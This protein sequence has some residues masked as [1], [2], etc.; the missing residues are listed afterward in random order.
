MTAWIDLI[1]AYALEIILIAVV[2][3]LLIVSLLWRLLEASYRQLWQWGRALWAQ[4]IDLAPVRRLL[5]KYPRLWALL[6]AR[7]SPDSYLGLHLTLGVLFMLAAV[8]LFGSL[9]EQVVEEESL[10]RF[11]QDLAAALH[12]QASPLE[13][14]IFRVVTK[15]ADTPTLVVI[16]LVV[17]LALGLRRRWL[18]MGSWAITVIGGALLNT[19]LKAIFQRPRP[20]FETPLLIEQYWSFPSAH[21][22][23]SLVTYGMLAYLLLVFLEPH[24][25]RIGG[26]L[27]V[28]LVLL[29]GF[30][31]LYLGVHYFSDV[32][33]GYT[34]GSVW[35]AIMIS[36][37]EVARRYQQMQQEQSKT[38]AAAR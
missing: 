28:A 34:A 10:V 22:M 20:E 32:I 37:T 27:L 26:A 35:L 6:G 36:G 29:I 12:Q 31:R 24:L 11:D 21:A 3:V 5:N 8:I 9:A 25:A 18:L 23:M 38:S 14:Q 15:F 13:V 33:A 17:G 30:S 16:D 2:V 7:F 19:L 1:G 4:V